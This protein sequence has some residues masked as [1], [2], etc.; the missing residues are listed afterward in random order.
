MTIKSKKIWFK[1]QL[2]ISDKENNHEVQRTK[3]QW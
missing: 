1:C 3:V 2:I